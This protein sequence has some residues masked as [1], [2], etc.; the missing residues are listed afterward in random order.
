[1][2]SFSQVKFTGGAFVVDIVVVG[3]EASVEVVIVIEGVID[4]VGGVVL[5]SVPD[6]FPAKTRFIVFNNG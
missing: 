4:E 1:M 6:S 5:I 3:I 2:P